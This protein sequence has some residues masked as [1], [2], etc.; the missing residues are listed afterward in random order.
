M[1]DY[2]YMKRCSIVHVY[3]AFKTL[4]NEIVTRKHELCEALITPNCWTYAVKSRFLGSITVSFERHPRNA[5]AVRG[6]GHCG[7][8]IPDRQSMHRNFL[9][10]HDNL[11]LGDDRK[12]ASGRQ[13]PNPVLVI[14][15]RRKG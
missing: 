6:F 4:D 15:V 12:A 8:D 3:I 2:I 9:Y 10:T 5:H 11:T 13:N 14:I 7:N 1:V